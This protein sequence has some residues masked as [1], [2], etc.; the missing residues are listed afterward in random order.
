MNF[1][2]ILLVISVLGTLSCLLAVIFLFR[3]EN[4]KTP[5]GNKTTNLMSIRLRLSSSDINI[6]HNTLLETYYILLSTLYPSWSHKSDTSAI[7]R[8]TKSLFTPELYKKIW[9]AHVYASRGMMNADEKDLKIM[10]NNLLK[11]IT[12]VS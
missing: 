3:A 6:L 2:V 5:M 12:T 9:Q 8:N 1:N 10:I 11:A 4:K 7:L